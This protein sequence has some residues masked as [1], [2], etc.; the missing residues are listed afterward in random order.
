MPGLPIASAVL[1]KYKGEGD[2]KATLRP[3]TPINDESTLGVPSLSALAEPL[4]IHSS[5]C[6]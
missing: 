2:E 6:R 4:L 3:Y 1:T 5:C